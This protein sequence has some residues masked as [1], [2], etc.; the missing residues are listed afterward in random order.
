LPGLSGGPGETRAQQRDRLARL[1]PATAV[2]G[3]AV[4]SGIILPERGGGKGVDWARVR[5][6][7]LYMSGAMAAVALAV[8][9]ALLWLR[10]GDTEPPPAALQRSAPATAPKPVEPA[11]M[12]QEML[13]MPAGRN[14]AG[15]LPGESQ[16]TDE[17]D[18]PADQIP[19][20]SP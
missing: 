15:G 18:G 7:V 16:G 8:L 17:E 20:P 4:P 3:T 12:P 2:A 11:A 1:P 19:P 13:H 6:R 9:A 10:S 5:N 14:P